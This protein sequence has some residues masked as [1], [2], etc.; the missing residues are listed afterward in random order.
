MEDLLNDDGKT[1][2]KKSKN[3]LALEK[4]E[5]N[6]RSVLFIRIILKNFCLAFMQSSYNQFLRNLRDLIAR[7]KLEYE[8]VSQYYWLIQFLTEFNR[9]VDTTDEQTKIEQIKE[10]FSVELFHSVEV[11]I[12]HCIEMMRVEKKQAR[13]WAKRMHTSLKCYKEN[14]ISMFVLEKKITKFNEENNLN[15]SEVNAV[16]PVKPVKPVGDEESDLVAIAE[17]LMDETEKNSMLLSDVDK[18]DILQT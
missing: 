4:D 8:E 16:S 15:S 7:K 3:K 9:N 14:L 12:Q 2:V 18:I 6:H 1:I 5:T 17:G 10:T 13:L 11:Y